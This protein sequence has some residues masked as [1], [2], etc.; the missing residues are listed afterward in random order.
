MTPYPLPLLR[1]KRFA[2]LPFRDGCFDAVVSVS[3]II[4]AM[5]RSIEK[6]TAEIHRVLRENGLLLTN[7]TSVRDP[8]YGKGEK[9]EH[10]TFKIQEAFEDKRFEEIHHFFTKKEAQEMFSSWTDSKI[11][12]IPEKPFYW[13]ALAVK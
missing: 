3:V 6:T 5:K 8:R 2:H 12:L 9:L 13:K 10:N 11:T 1:A 4:H 7:L